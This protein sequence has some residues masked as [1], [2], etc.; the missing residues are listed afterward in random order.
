MR[1]DKSVI[2]SVIRVVL[3]TNGMYES[4]T[5]AEVFWAQSVKLQIVNNCRL[6][7][8]I[9]ELN[10]CGP[11]TWMTAIYTSVRVCHVLRYIISI[12]ARS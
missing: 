9:A 3:L 11:K 4:K 10:I 6:L 7:H 12:V 5:E 2:D 8:C 1:M